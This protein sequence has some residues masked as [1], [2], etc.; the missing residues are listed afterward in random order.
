MILDNSEWLLPLNLV[1]F[2]RDVGSKFTV[3]HMLAHETYRVRL[4]QGGLSFLEFSYQLL[5]AYD[6]LHL[7]RH[8]DCDFQVGGSDQW[9]NILAGVDLIR[10]TDQKEAFALVW[11]LITTSSGAKMG[12]T[13]AGAVWLNHELLPVYD[14]YQFWINTED[15]DVER[16]LALFTF[17][18]MHDI[19][20]LAALPGAEIREAKEVLAFEAT[21]IVHG[22][23]AAEEA[24][25]TSHALF[26]GDGSIVSAP[27][28]NFP[29]ERFESGI[30]VVDLAHEVG[31]FA[32]RREARRK[33]DEGGLTVNGRRV[34]NQEMIRLE[35][36]ATD[37]SLLL[38]AG[39]K[40]YLRVLAV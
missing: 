1:E 18:P 6:F 14:Y 4:E 23:E 11:P 26:G 30:G 21:T 37:Q 3:N 13:A 2:L 32:S 27:S 10:R 25:R 40:H 15:A 7:F 12:K 17:L 16:F 29:R 8:H 34:A 39:K 38:R 31:L 33:I 5:Q 22:R 20:R 9:A 36:L 28:A 24:R 35:D 19:K